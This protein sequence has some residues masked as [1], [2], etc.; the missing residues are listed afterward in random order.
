[1]C[2]T[3]TLTLGIDNEIALPQIKAKLS[4]KNEEFGIDACFSVIKIIQNE[5]HSAKGILNAND[6]KPY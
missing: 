5:L 1:M 6:R 4:G 3:R 2:P